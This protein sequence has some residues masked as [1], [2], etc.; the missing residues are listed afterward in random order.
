MKRFLL[1]P[2]FAL[3][4][5]VSVAGL[6]LAERSLEGKT[7]YLQSNLWFEY[8]MK[9]NAINYHKGTI[10]EA[11][12]KVKVDSISSRALNF[13]TLRNGL[14]YRILFSKKYFPGTDMDE[15]AEWYFGPDNPLKGS[16]YAGFSSIEKKGIAEGTI[17]KGMSKKAVL[18]A[19]GYPPRHRTRSLDLNTWSYWSNRLFRMEVR[20]GKDGRVAE[21]IGGGH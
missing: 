16:V 12:T 9:I 20:F 11:G 2:A 1:I 8:P 17:K 7:L 6:S 15:F 5:A 18:M 21:I 4:L 14:E 10:L 13:T 3:V 19:Y